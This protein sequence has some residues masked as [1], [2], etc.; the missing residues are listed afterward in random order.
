[1]ATYRLAC[2]RDWPT[3]RC[4]WQEGFPTDTEAQIGRFWQAVGRRVPC[5]LR[6][7]GEAVTS[8]AFLIP[9]A[10][11]LNGVRHSLYYVYAAVTARAFRGR[12]CFGE[13]LEQAAA[14]AAQNGVEALFLR[15]GEPGLF[16]Y[17]RRCGFVPAFAARKTD[18]KVDSLAMQGDVWQPD[19]AYA[20]HREQWLKSRRV[21]FVEWPE[22][23][24]DY[25]VK[26]AENSGGGAFCSCQAAALVERDGTRLTVRE[27]LCDSAPISRELLEAAS[28]TP[29]QEILTYSPNASNE[30]L[31]PFGMTRFLPNWR[32]EVLAK[33]NWYM[34]LTLE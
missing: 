31:P 7:E 27:W 22:F 21:P 12:G 15:P 2:E 4:L 28:E 26:E 29:C 34:G 32:G 3:V 5:L 13:W 11:T 14:Y 1:M 8:L 16:A 23:V 19:T 24:V 6:C 9:A 30:N 17:Y 10:I 33:E 20:A 18:C 25:A